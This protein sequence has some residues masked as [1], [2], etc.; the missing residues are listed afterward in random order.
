M[1]EIQTPELLQLI[2][3]LIVNLVSIIEIWGVY[4]FGIL[5]LF[6]C[7]WTIFEIMRATRDGIKRQN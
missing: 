4:I 5:L 1:V 2:N 6:F 7:I 3:G